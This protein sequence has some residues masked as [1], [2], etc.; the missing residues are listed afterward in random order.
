MHYI[1]SLILAVAGLTVL[2]WNKPLSVQLGHFY[3]HR[4]RMTFGRLSQFLEWDNP[5]KPSNVF[6]YRLVVIFIGLFC[7]IMAFHFFFG[8]IYI[9]NTEPV[10]TPTSES[11]AILYKHY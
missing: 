9:G 3:A 11:S 7:L 6:L 5:T 10:G 4:F 2:I 1:L 8:T